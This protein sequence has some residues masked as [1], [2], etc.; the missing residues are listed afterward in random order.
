MLK[1]IL[2]DKRGG[3]GYVGLMVSLVIS[4]VIGAI[5]YAGIMGMLSGPVQNGLGKAF[6]NAEKAATGEYIQYD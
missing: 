4:L 1:K 3:D 6:D 5:V 2:T